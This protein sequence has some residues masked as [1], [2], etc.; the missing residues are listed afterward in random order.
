SAVDRR[1]GRLPLR[2]H[3]GH[4]ECAALRIGDRAA[5]V[6]GRALGH[7]LSAQCN[8]EGENRRDSNGDE[9]RGHRTSPHLR[10]RHLLRKNH[11]KKE[12]EMTTTWM[13]GVL[14]GSLLIC[15]AQ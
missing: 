3:E 13:A 12:H 9:V 15:A 5:D 10:L 7:C 11:Q 4:R 2:L 6:T 1:S 8:G 14:A